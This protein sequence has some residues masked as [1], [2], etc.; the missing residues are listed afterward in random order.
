MNEIEVT[1]RI[2][3]SSIDHKLNPQLVATGEGTQDRVDGYDLEINAILWQVPDLNGN[4]ITVN[5]LGK[6][7]QALVEEA[8]FNAL[9]L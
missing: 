3:L 9:N 1:V 8:V 2:P 4:L 7:E 5:V 6:F